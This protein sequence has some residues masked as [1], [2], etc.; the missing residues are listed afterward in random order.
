MGMSDLFNKLLI[1]RTPGI[2]PAKYNSLLARFE[3]LDAAVASLQVDVQLRDNVLREMERAEKLN[4]YYICDDDVRYPCALRR[5]KNHPP[6][7]TVRGNLDV[8]ARPVV[9]MGG[10][11]HATAT[12]MGF[13][14][15]LAQAFAENNYAVVSGM[16][17]GTDTAAHKGALRASGNAQTIAVLAGGADYIWPVENESLY[18]EILE[19]GAII[20][21]MPVGFVPVATNFIQ[22]N[23]HVAGIADKL[24]LGEAD[25]KS[26][27]MA[28]A[29]FAIDYN[30]E[31]WAIPSHPTDSRA[32]G[33]NSLI[34]SGVAR[35]CSG[36][37]DFFD[38]DD[39]HAENKKMKKDSENDLSLIDKIG[40]VPVSESVLADVVGKTVSEIKSELVILE[41]QGLV[42]KVDGGYVR[43]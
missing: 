3:S 16:A 42:R 1:L 43:L 14:A 9:V 35:L 27:S 25:I 21:E 28:T 30:R 38:S 7:I 41:L 10:T 32:A 15:D 6:V 18:Y 19:R 17:V 20:S 22:R 13:I 26:G 24:I 29:R 37:Q 39:K 34:K 23:R 12:G 4:V 5:V 36:V 2:G 40:M 8:V 33:P 11:R 31:V